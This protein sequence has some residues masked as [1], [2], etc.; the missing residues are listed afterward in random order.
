[1]PGLEYPPPPIETQPPTPEGAPPAPYIPAETTPDVPSWEVALEEFLSELL[2]IFTP[3]TVEQG[4]WGEWE[5]GGWE[6]FRREY[7]FVDEAFPDWE[8]VGFYIVD[9]VTE[10]VVNGDAVPYVMTLQGEWENDEKWS[11]THIATS[12]YLYD[13][14]EDGIP[15]LLIR[16]ST[17]G[18][19]P[20][21]SV[22]MFRYTGGKYEAVHI[23]RWSFWQEEFVDGVELFE[24]GPS[25]VS[26]LL[27]RDSE[28]RTIVLSMGGAGGV[29]SSAHILNSGND[30]ISLDPI[31]WMRSGW[32]G[33]L[34]QEFTLFL[35]ESITGDRASLPEMGGDDVVFFP[36]EWLWGEGDM[37]PVPLPIMPDITVA[38]LPRLTGLEQR[39]TE[40][41][42]ARLLAEGRILPI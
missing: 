1:M 13:M 32:G 41:V 27:A 25:V 30:G 15:I 39:L 3:G 17:L 40:S 18:G 26:G 6:R 12:F 11:I 28:G 37:T 9:P 16:W 38:P 20:F 36:W 4:E 34:E 21:E 2:P 22:S 23:S 24:F 31:F 35:N 7:T 8:Q 29:E 10:E 5:I 14:D 33:G 42:T 19:D